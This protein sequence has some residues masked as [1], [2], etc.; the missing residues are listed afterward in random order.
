MTQVKEVVGANGSSQNVTN[1]MEMLISL[2]H[3]LERINFAKRTS[4]SGRTEE[5]RKQNKMN[6]YFKIKDEIKVLLGVISAVVGGPELTQQQMAFMWPWE[7]KW[8]SRND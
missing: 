3:E 6:A 4:Y 1:L 2:R 8:R 5:Q 7:A